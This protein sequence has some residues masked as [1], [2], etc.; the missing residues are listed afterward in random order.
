MGPD[1]PVLATPLTICLVVLGRGSTAGISGGPSGNEPA[2]SPSQL[3]YQRLLAGDPV[4]AIDQA[5]EFLKEKL[6]MNLR[7]VLEV[8][9]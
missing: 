1:R 2:L 6:L 8:F 5:E 7:D 3:V 4:E 9:D